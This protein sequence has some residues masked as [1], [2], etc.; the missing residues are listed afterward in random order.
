MID[1]YAIS[2][3]QWEKLRSYVRDRSLAD[4]QKRMTAAAKKPRA[5]RGSRHRAFV[6]MMAAAGVEVA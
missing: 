2:P 3:E 6:A 5:A 4:F 1:V